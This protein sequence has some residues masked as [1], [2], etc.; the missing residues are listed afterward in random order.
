MKRE[1]HISAAAL[2]VSYGWDYDL[3]SAED[4]IAEYMEDHGITFTDDEIQQIIAAAPEA[5]EVNPDE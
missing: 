1:H 4:S 3:I 5:C 2:E